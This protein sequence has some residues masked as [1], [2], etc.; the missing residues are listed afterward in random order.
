MGHSVIGMCGGVGML[1][2]GYVPSLW[3]AGSLSMQ[4]FSFGIAGA[5]VG[6]WTGARI[7]ES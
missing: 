5:I 3:G 6:I 1:L 4:S 7:A 2:G